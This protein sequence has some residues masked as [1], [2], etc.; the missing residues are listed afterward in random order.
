M[1]I[2]VSIPITGHD[3]NKVREHADLIKRALSVKGNKVTTPFEIFCGKNP[4]YADYIGNDIRVI[5]KQDAV[6]FCKGWEESCGC[7][8]EHDVVMRV[9]A[10]GI[11]NIKVMYED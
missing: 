11:K 9:K 2:Y 1:D 8:I 10:H 3:I 5:L 4:E 7:N 6:F